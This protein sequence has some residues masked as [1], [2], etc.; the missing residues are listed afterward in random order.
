MA[1]RRKAPLCE[2]IFGQ[3]RIP[4]GDPE[5][6]KRVIEGIFMIGE[7]GEGEAKP[8][9]RRRAGKKARRKIRA[10][11]SSKTKRIK[12]IALLKKKGL[13]ASQIAKK[14]GV[15]AMTVSRDLKELKKES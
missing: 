1:A 5:K 10:R 13:N 11:R 3:L 7:A 12:R 14:V 15:S 8:R 9:G 2:I 6:G 4:V